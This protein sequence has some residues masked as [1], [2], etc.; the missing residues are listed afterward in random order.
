MHLHKIDTQSG[1]NG[2]E[3]PS[4]Y[5]TAPSVWNVLSTFTAL[6]QLARQN[7][8]GGYHLRPVAQT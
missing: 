3:D 2:A 6:H 5:L 4:Q 7:A 1:K 8:D